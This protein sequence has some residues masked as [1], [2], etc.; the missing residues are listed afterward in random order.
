MA[1]ANLPKATTVSFA[2][3]ER[4]G[5]CRICVRLTRL[6]DSEFLAG[7]ETL[8]LLVSHLREAEIEEVQFSVDLDKLS[9][10]V[11]LNLRRVY[12]FALPWSSQIVQQ[13]LSLSPS[14]SG[15]DPGITSA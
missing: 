11:N 3:R 4:G 13:F 8:T 10:H 1:T 7:I 12:L 6:E 9:Y 14:I 5:V 15:I 2:I